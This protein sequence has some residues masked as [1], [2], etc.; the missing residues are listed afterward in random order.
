MTEIKQRRLPST[1][2]MV[3]AFLNNTRFQT[4][5][6]NGLQEINQN[7]DG[8]EYHSHYPDGAHLLRNKIT[9]KY[10][11]IR[12]PYGRIGDSILITETWKVCGYKLKTPE[13]QI[14]YK[15]GSNEPY[16][17]EWRYVTWELHEKYKQ[18]NYYKWH[19]GR[20]MPSFASRI[21]RPI[22]DIRIQR[23]QD[24]SEGDAIAEGVESMPG[25]S[26]YGFLG[27][28]AQYWD[29]INAIDGMGW[30][31]NPWVFCLTL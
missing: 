1:A 24:I 29:S 6:L 19:T 9:N 28:F 27:I 23:I 2:D 15:T 31:F 3:K 21:R 13:L 16:D 8:W 11:T 4:R 5:R 20:F 30:E 22:T 26:D 14:G 10:E 12:C 18:P 25:S 17:A 7:P